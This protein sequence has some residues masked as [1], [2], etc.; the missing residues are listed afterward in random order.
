MKELI[1]K[2]YQENDGGYVAKTKLEKGSIITEGD[3]LDELKNM[4]IDAVKGFFFDKP[5]EMP[6]SIRL[7]FVKVNEEIFAL[8]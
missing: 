8:A 1:F 5:K 7:H 2:V 4:I 3:N 6:D